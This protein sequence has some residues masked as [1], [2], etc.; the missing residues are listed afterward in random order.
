MTG[1]GLTTVEGSTPVRFDIQIIGTMENA[2]APGFDLV[3]FEIT[4]PQS[5]LDQAHGMAAGM[6][7]SPIYIQGELAGAAS[8]RFYF[9]D[10]NIGLFTP[11]QKMVDMLESSGGSTVATPD[12]IAVTRPARRAVAEAAG[13]PVSRVPASAQRLPI[14]LGVTGVSD[15]QIEDLQSLLQKKGLP[16]TVYRA[17]VASSVTTL[18]PTPLQP[19]QPL[20]AALSY[21]DVSE[22]ATGTATFTCGTLDVGFG[23]PFFFEG[24]TAF[25]MNDADIVTVINDPSGFEGPFKVANLAEGHGTITEDHLAGIVGQAGDLPE[26]MPVTTSFTN[27]DNGISRNGE[28]DIVYQKGFWGPEIAASHVFSN[29]QLVFD[30]YSSGTTSLSYTIQGRTSSGTTFTVSNRNMQ[31]S[32]YDATEAAYRL[33]DAMYQ[34]AFNRFE[35]VTFTS[36][37]AQGEITR[38]ELEGRITSIRTASPMQPTLAQ[39]SVLKAAPGS[40][41][42]VEIGLTPAEGGP[43]V[44][45]TVKMKVPSWARGLER[46]S[47][48]GGK[49]RS[50]LLS[51]GRIRSFGELIQI[52]NDGGHPN[53]LI[54]S[55]LG[56]DITKVMDLVVKGKGFFNVRVVR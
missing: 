11:A 19:G 21:G 52:L 26:A 39:R 2:V 49:A 25:G 13:V 4:G 35:P 3:I 53:D 56:S 9:S 15:R 17:G 38:H 28:T 32:S 6:S 50:R 55:G 43:N 36:V 40:T 29:L 22:F 1:T 23:H 42:R 37:H 18:D 10:A 14:P 44:V 54:V 51:R 33:L 48:R 8:Y 34:L 16:F 20:S 7:G 30:A 24:Q 12:S 47:L 31:Y 45:T 5:F 27:M 41:I 46:V